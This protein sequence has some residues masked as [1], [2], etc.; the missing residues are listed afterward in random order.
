MSFSSRLLMWFWMAILTAYVMIHVR[1]SYH[2]ELFFLFDDYELDTVFDIIFA[3]LA[4]CS[5]LFWVFSNSGSIRVPPTHK[6][7]NADPINKNLKDPDLHNQVVKSICLLV[8]TTFY[9]SVMG[10]TPNRLPI[11]ILLSL[12]GFGLYLVLDKIYSI[13]APHHALHPNIERVVQA[14][15]GVFGEKKEAEN[16]TQTPKSGSQHTSHGSENGH[17]GYEEGAGPINDF[18]FIGDFPYGIPIA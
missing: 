8:F 6:P 11:I 5:L 17:G 12:L 7:R 13:F 4:I 1:M 18:D 2:H 9:L 14:I 3:S 10:T 16:G 15:G